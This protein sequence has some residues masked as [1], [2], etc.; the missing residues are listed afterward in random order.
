MSARSLSLHDS[1]HVARLQPGRG[2]PSCSR[3]LPYTADTLSTRAQEVRLATTNADRERIDELANL[4][5]LV[6][7]LNYLERAYVRDSITAAQ[8]VHSL[9]PSP[10]LV[11]LPGLMWGGRRSLARSQVRSSLHKAPRSVQDH[12]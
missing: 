10:L 9:L 8:C 12:H 11:L 3:A 7:S 1:D 6:L 5:S 4:Y 2:A